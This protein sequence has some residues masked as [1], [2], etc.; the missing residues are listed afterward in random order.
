MR[1]LF[2]LAL[3]G[4][5]PFAIAQNTAAEFR[6]RCQPSP[7]KEVL[8]S[9]DFKW[10]YSLSELLSKFTE[11]YSSEKRLAQ[12]AYWDDKT[13]TLRLPF[14]KSRGGDVVITEKFVQSIAD[15]IEQAFQLNVIDGVFFPDM[16]HSHLLIPENIYDSKYKQIPV[17][18][19]SR[20]Y[21]EFYNDSDIKILYHTAEQLQ[22]T[23]KDG[24]V[25]D[26]PRVRWR[27]QTRNLVGGNFQKS[28]L[29]FFQNPD[30]RVNTVHEVAGYHWWGGGFNLSAN[31]KG[32]FSYQNNNQIYYFDISLYDLETSPDSDVW[33]AVRNF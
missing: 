24:R 14:D 2:I 30:S 25:I 31:K 8:Y 20:M 19:M 3:I 15:H 33:G 9:N 1:S 4:Y 22:M 5:T 32:C 6:S 23:E 7:Q 13:Q 28:S 11:I 26:N 17:D 29:E 27:H 12:R 10:G 16:G 21:E 18:Q